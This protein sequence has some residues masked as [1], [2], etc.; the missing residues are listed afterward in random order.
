V[1]QTLRAFW[2]DHY[3]ETFAQGNTWLDYSNERVQV[4]TFGLCIDAS[5]GVAGRRCLD[6]GAGQGQ[7]ARSLLALDANVIAVDLLADVIARHRD[8]TPRIEWRAGN[9]L[10]PAFV[11]DL[12][13]CE[14]VFLLEI[15]Q[16]VPWRDVLPA[17]WAKVAPGGRLVAVVPNG[18]CPIVRRTIARYEGNYTAPS[19]SD[20]KATA[21]TLPGVDVWVYR[22]LHFQ[23]D[24]RRSPY[25]VTAWTSDVEWEVPPNRL[26]IVM[27]RVSA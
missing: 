6:V 10:D 26:Q 12:P 3:R 16:C 5:G 19:V 13:V 23:A 11:A 25:D 24:Q 9:V 2:E 18:E 14:R 20:L 1:H 4:Q 7:F 21:G 22:G 15:L 27:Q 17:M 8:A